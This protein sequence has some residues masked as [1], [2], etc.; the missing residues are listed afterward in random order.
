MYVFFLLIQNK[1]FHYFSQV[2]LPILSMEPVLQKEL[3]DVLKTIRLDRPDNATGN[4]K[5]SPVELLEIR[6]RLQMSNYLNI[7]MHR[8]KTDSDYN[9]HTSA[10]IDEVFSLVARLKHKTDF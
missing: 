2:R 8:L 5:M 4:K 9:H 6:A 3:N 1:K 7:A 10:R